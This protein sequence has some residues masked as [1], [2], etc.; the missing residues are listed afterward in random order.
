M[1]NSKLTRSYIENQIRK[2]TFGVLSTVSPKG[3]AQSSGVLYGV[4]DS[5]EV[6]KIYILTGKNYKK[7]E[8]IA[9]NPNVSFTITFPHYYF[10]MVPASTIQFQA[11]ARLVSIDDE[12]ALRSYKKKR[13]LRMVLNWDDEYEKEDMV[14]IE[15][16]P[17]SKYNCYGV[18][19]PFIHL[20][21][22]AS[23]AFYQIK[24]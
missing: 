3:R 16:I 19:F 8:N 24:M 5:S 21:R 6:L 2:K 17:I 13:I 1:N 22:H 15:L 11:S 20:A 12:K 14:F 4:S 9:K 18:G 7:V 10:R 23:D